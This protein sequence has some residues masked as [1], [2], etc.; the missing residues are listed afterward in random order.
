MEMGR[1]S[2]RCLCVGEVY[3]I[4]LLDKSLCLAITPRCHAKFRNERLQLSRLLDRPSDPPLTPAQAQSRISSQLPM[5]SKLNYATQVIDNSGSI[6]DLNL[7]IDRL[8]KRW[9]AQQGGNSGWWW[10]LC[11]IVPPL[12]LVA[13]GLCLLQNWWNAKRSGRRRGRGEVDKRLGTEGE[14]IELRDRRRRRNTGSSVG[15]D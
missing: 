8:I 9:K 15:S 12:G 4:Y 10:R 2:G 13:G 3:L 5:S 1:G 14:S 11:W 6:Q 7:Q